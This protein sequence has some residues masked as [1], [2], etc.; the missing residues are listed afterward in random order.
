MVSVPG[1]VGSAGCLLVAVLLVAACGGSSAPASTSAP[2]PSPAMTSAPTPAITSAPTPAATAA[3]TAPPATSPPATAAAGLA[4]DLVTPGSLIICSSFPRPRF[5]ER[6][7]SGKAIGVDIEIGEALARQLGLAPEI[8]ELLFDELIDAVEG[9][10]CDVS[11]AGQFITSGRLARIDMIPYREGVGHVIVRAGNPLAIVE[12]TDL[13][14]RSLAVVAGTV[15][16]EMVRGTG[17]YAGR[18]IDDQCTAA[19][20][21]AVNIVEFPAQREAE[22]ALAQGDVDA[23]AGNDFV[24]I[25]RPADFA[26]S[27]DLPPTRNGIGVRLGAGALNAGLREAFRSIIDGGEYLEILAAHGA[28]GLRT[29]SRP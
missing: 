24:T 28:T 7:A 26:L 29:T 14:G 5:A 16:I 23:Y 12:L 11:I 3:Q 22:D 6:D 17:D 27:A 1:R 9:R 10:R 25:D 18:G 20:A 4:G 2:T 15:H 19:S 13:C 8:R 21:P